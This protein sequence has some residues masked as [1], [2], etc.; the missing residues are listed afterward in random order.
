MK[1]PR[2]GLWFSRTRLNRSGGVAPPAGP[3]NREDAL[4]VRAGKLRQAVGNRT[5]AWAKLTP[6]ERSRPAV[7]PWVFS[8]GRDGYVSAGGPTSDHRDLALPVVGFALG[9]DVF[10]A[11]GSMQPRSGD[12][13]RSAGTLT[14]H[15][16]GHQESD[17][18]VA[19]WYLSNS[20]GR[21]HRICEKRPNPWG[22]YD[23]HGNVWEWTTDWYSDYPDSDAA[24]PWGPSHGGKRVVRGGLF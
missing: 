18:D 14:H 20:G 12:R 8:V 9:S 16:S 1:T 19:A 24:N 7:V 21:I 2:S 10:P 4:Q 15:W 23:M 6:G 17:L 13:S 22:L 11:T 3:Q 5:P